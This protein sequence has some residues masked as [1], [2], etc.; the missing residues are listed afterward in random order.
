MSLLSSYSLIQWSDLRVSLHPLVHSWIRDSLVDKVQLRHW[1]SSLS[2]L[3][4]MRGRDDQSYSYYRRLT[5]HI[6]S[7]LEV[8]DL[9]YLLIED[10]V[11]KERARV[12]IYL[13]DVYVHCSQR[14]ELLRLSES[15]LEYTRRTLGD[16]QQLTWTLLEYNTLAHNDLHQFQESIDKLE[17]LLEEFS[18]SPSPTPPFAVRA[19]ARLMLAYDGSGN[20]KNALNLGEKLVPLCIDT[21]GEDAMI[22]CTVMHTLSCG[23]STS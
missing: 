13:L 18:L 1:T 17:T 23:Q 5:P 16:R 9:E 2:T 3:A 14:R 7:C 21:H 22:T 15:A 8:R 10:S 11:V 19:M 12:T 4:I 20:T 6:Q